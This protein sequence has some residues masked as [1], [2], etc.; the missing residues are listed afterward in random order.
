MSAGGAPALA[1][2]DEAVPDELPSPFL[3]AN[4]FLDH[5]W[6]PFLKPAFAVV[7]S[8]GGAAVSR[9]GGGAVSPVPLRMKGR[10][11]ELE[12]CPKRGYR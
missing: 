4:R 2:L 8:A 7:L 6:F 11:S 9:G 12:V 3:V 5:F 10:P 1:E